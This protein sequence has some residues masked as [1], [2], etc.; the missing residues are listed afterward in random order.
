MNKTNFLGKIGILIS[1]ASLFF[2]ATYFGKA[3]TY[4]GTLFF[5]IGLILGMGLL[6]LDELF[7]YKYYDLKEKQLV[8][9]SLIFILSL[10]PLGIFLMTSTGSATGVGMFLGIISSLALDIFTYKKDL[11]N[12]QDRFF[13]QL[14]RKVTTTEHKIFTNLFI[15]L[16]ILYAF[17]VIFLGR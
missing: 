17:I 13:Y 5:S 6:E 8:T 12:F 15:I 11:K 7:L 2:L 16:T 9:R 4:S 10:F 14:K 1:Y 3:I